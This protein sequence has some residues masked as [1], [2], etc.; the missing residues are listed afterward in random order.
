[1]NHNVNWKDLMP[2]SGI[3][4]LENMCEYVYTH[5]VCV[6]ICMYILKLFHIQ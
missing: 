4:E 5:A 6:N 1:M 2:G 3:K